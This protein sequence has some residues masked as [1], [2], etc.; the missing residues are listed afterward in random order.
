MSLKDTNVQSS[1]FV[2]QSSGV[3]ISKLKWGQYGNS[4]Q[5]FRDAYCTVCGVLVVEIVI[6]YP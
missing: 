4:V 5:V 1:W 3:V 6:V 2:K